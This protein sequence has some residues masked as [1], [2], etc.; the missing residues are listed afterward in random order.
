MPRTGPRV[1]ERAHGTKACYLKGSGPGSGK[2]C[3]C[4]RCKKAN[5]AWQIERERAILRGD[6][7][8]WTDAEPVRAHVETLIAAGLTQENVAALAGINPGSITHLM[9]GSNGHPPGKKIRPETA[10]KIRAVRS[11]EVLP[12]AGLVRSTGTVRRLQALVAIGWSMRQLAARLAMKPQNFIIMMRGDQVRPS[13]AAAVRELYDQLWNQEPPHDTARQ[14]VTIRQSRARA[15]AEGWPPPWAWNDHEI[16][17]PAA[18]PAGGLAAAGDGKRHHGSDSRESFLEL[19]SW[20]LSFEKA[21][22]RMDVSAR[23]LLRWE[24]DR[25]KTEAEGEEAIAS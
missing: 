25:I 2:G 7:E 24:A 21:A 13:T 23:T 9:K 12:A 19:R 14:A 16:D 15:E 10:R 17:N 4:A 5:R 1:M 11:F 6:W 3:R 8:P 20:G 18:E 22:E